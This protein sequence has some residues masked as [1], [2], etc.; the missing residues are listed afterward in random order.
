MSSKDAILDVE[1]LSVSLPIDG[2][3]TP[4]VTDISFSIGRGEA[5]ALVGESGCG[6]SMT[7]RAVIGLTPPGARVQGAIRLNGQEV[8]SLPH[9][10]RRSLGGREIGF[11][12]QE[13]MTSLHPTLTIG[14][15][16]TEGMRQH[17][18]LSRRAA[19]ER[20]REL[21]DRVGVPRSGAILAGYAHELSGGM[22]QRVVVAMAIS[23]GPSLVIADEPTTALDVTIQAQVLDLLRSMRDRM[24]LAMLYITHDL[25]VVADFCDRAIVMYA[26]DRI[27]EGLPSDCLAAPRHPYTRGLVDAIPRPGAHA[28]R[29]AAIPGQVPPVGAWPSGCRF[30]PRCARRIEAC[31]MRPALDGGV[32]C[33]RP[34]EN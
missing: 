1:G 26:G 34:L 24:G 6:K 13:P 15:Q 20:A 17:L 4:I 22:R 10:Q 25:D 2:V 11:V 29:L 32:R 14:A 5:L 8:S 23:C 33:W 21:L 19:L 3:M 16:M 28:E 7:A 18:G 27:E 30:A 31:D 12:F 9:K